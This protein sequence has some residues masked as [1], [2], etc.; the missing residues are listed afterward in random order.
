MGSHGTVIYYAAETK[1]NI[2]VIKAVL[3][4]KT[5]TSRVVNRKD[6]SCGPFESAKYSDSP[7][8]YE[9]MD[10]L[11]SKGCRRSY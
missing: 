8:K 3:N 4:H 9:I 2:G 10:L 1:K 7:L 11:E 5:C 6:G